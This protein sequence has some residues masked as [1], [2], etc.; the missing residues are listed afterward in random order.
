MAELAD[1][2]QCRNDVYQEIISEGLVGS[3]QQ[4]ILDAV[5]RNPG[6]TGSEIAE[7]IGIQQRGTVS[8][9]ICELASMGLVERRGKRKCSLTNRMSSLLWFTRNKPVHPATATQTCPL[10]N[11]AGR[12]PQEKV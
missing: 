5:V 10:C 12:I 9:R 8:A 6:K 3:M 7:C 2:E 4:S 11:G 1:G